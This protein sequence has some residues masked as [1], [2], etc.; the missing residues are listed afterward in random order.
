MDFDNDLFELLKALSKAEIKFVVCG[1]VACVLH[2]V[3]RATYGLD[4]SVDFDKS[5]LQK[6]IDLAKKFG[7]SPRNP[8]P[9]EK[10]FEEENRNRRI[11]EKN[12]LV[13]TFVAERSPIQLDIFLSY[14]LNFEELMKNSETIYLDEVRVNVSSVKDLLYAKEFIK[15]ARDKDLIDIKELKRLNEQTN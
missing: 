14:P 2:G 11:A 9:V 5:N 4:I 3:E 12:A 8:E 10:L 1:G 15:P 13:Y 6:I 7:L